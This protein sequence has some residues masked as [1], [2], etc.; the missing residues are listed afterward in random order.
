M[1]NHVCV[2]METFLDAVIKCCENNNSTITKRKIVPGANRRRVQFRYR[3][4]DT[5]PGTHVRVVG[6]C[7]AL[8]SWNPE[9]AAPLQTSP[10][11]FPCWRSGEL[12]VGKDEIAQNTEWQGIEYK[13]VICTEG[14]Q[15]EKWEECENRMLQPTMFKPYSVL[16]VSESFD[17]RELTYHFSSLEPDKPKSMEVHIRRQESFLERYGCEAAEFEQRYCLELPSPLAEGSF[18]VIWV[19][20]ECSCHQKKVLRAVKI[21]Q[22]AKLHPRD[23]Q[24]L[25]GD[26]G[27]IQTHLGLK[28][29]H[30]IAL[31]EAFD[32]IYTVSLVM[33]YARGGDL[34]DVI[35]ANWRATGLGISEIDA[36]VAQRQILD[37]LAYLDSQRIAHRDMK[38]ENILLVHEKV[39]LRKNVLKLCD[40]GFAKYDNGSGLTDM[41]GSPDTIAPEIIMRNSYGRKVDV[42]SAGVILFMMLSGTSPFRAPTYKEVVKRVRDN[43]WSM[44]GDAWNEVSDLAKACVRSMMTVDPAKRPTAKEVLRHSLWLA[45]HHDISEGDPY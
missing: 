33:E 44:E 16:V 1:G 8:G 36:S 28:H 38:C 23:F 21:I 43:Q 20:S 2:C 6:S 17:S 24:L 3:C 37:A 14:G 45:T 31:Y 11:D 7:K 39:P 5:R 25:L 29:K 34:A 35:M 13:Y 18:S 27:E 4:E 22:K 15:A 12:E 9:I 41:L 19:C 30:I 26:D 40:F 42:W 10:E 32:D